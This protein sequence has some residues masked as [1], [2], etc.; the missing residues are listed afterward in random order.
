MMDKPLKKNFVHKRGSTNKKSARTHSTN[1]IGE[2]V[3]HKRNSGLLRNGGRGS[4]MIQDVCDYCLKYKWMNRNQL[5]LRKRGK[6]FMCSKCRNKE[7]N[8]EIIEKKRPIPCWEN[9]YKW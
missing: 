9:Q 8:E 1:T 4:K 3:E 7:E 2:M 5:G 6:T